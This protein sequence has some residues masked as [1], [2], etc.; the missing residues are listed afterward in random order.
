VPAN[1]NSRLLQPYGFFDLTF[2]GAIIAFALAF[3][4]FMGVQTGTGRLGS[5]EITVRL[6]SAAGLRLGTDVQIAGLK[7]GRVGDIVLDPR[8]YAA[9]LTLALRDDLVLPSDSAF[10]IESSPM[11]ESYLKITPGRSVKTIAPGSVVSQPGS[12]VSDP[13]PNV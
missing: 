4:L 13:V 11:S 2:G 3:L 7:A 8:T 5:Y 12:H 1:A 6:K 9:R 10:A